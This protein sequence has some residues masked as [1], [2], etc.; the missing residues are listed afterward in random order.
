M[1]S[2]LKLL[3]HSAVLMLSIPPDLTGNRFSGSVR[4]NP[5]TSVSACPLHES[6]NLTFLKPSVIFG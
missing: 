6:G 1:S 5:L 4:H 2:Q 3:Y